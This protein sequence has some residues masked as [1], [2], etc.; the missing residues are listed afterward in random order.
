MTPTPS[1][2]KLSK[3]MRYFWRKMS[4]RNSRLVESTCQNCKSFVGASTRPEILDF[5]E[6]LHMCAKLSQKAHMP[7]TLPV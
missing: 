6:K 5:V 2:P 7:T 4:P 1:E 3:A